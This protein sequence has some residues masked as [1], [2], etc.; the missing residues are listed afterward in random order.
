MGKICDHLDVEDVEI[1][2]GRR[3]DFLFHIPN[4]FL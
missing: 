3:C 4:F 2:I 1:N